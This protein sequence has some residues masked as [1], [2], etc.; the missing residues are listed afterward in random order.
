VVAGSGKER[1]SRRPRSTAAARELSRYLRLPSDVD[2]VRRRSWR[3]S[4]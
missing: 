4:I 2:R 1:R 3:R